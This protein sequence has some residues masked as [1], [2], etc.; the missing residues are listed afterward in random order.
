MSTLPHAM[1]LRPSI[2]PRDGGEATGK[3][4]FA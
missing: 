4:R 3:E 2:F 1:P